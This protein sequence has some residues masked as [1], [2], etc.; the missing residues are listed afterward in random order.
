MKKKQWIFILIISILCLTRGSSTH[1]QYKDEQQII[2]FHVIA[3]SDSMED[4]ALKLKV[5]DKLLTWFGDDLKENYSI[6]DSRDIIEQQITTIQEVAQQEVRNLGQGYSVRAE[7]GQYSFPTRAYGTMVLPAGNYEA[8]RIIIGAGQGANW[9][10]VMFPP[11]C[12]VDITHGVI[13]EGD[14]VENDTILN[15]EMLSKQ[16]GNT[17]I[18]YG[19]KIVEW[20]KES[21]LKISLKKIYAFLSSG[22]IN[23]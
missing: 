20:W 4:Q 10:C 13:K 23:K 16:G 21:K 12:F 9:W 1:S 5:R 19:L 2:R 18:K 6:Q 3:N 15:I 11:L 22:K 8:L 17:E 14:N 7:L